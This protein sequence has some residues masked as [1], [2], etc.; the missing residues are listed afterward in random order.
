[1]KIAVLG[2]GAMGCLYG[3][4][5][6]EAGNEVCLIDVWKEHVEAINKSGLKIEGISGDRVIK[7]VKSTTT[8]E[9][10]GA[11]DLLIV[12]VKAT[13]TKEAIRGAVSLIGENTLIL[14]LQNGLGNIEKIS[15]VIGEEK[16][17]A[18]TT[19][20][21]STMLGPGH[22]RHAGTG[23]TKIGELDGSISERVQKLAKVFNDAGF[24]TQVADNVKGLIW[25]KLMANIGINA[26][27]ALTHLQ[28][29]RLLE[30]KETEE[31]LELVVKEAAEIA[32]K[33]NIKLEHDPVE[34][35][36]KVAKL[37]AA[38]RSSM[39]QDVS[40]KRMTEIAV[41]NG[42][43]VEKGEEYGVPTPVNKVLS[44]LISV[45]QRTY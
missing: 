22:I 33:E 31:L 40:R 17:I 45:I 14:T 38:N 13:L 6:A 26:L 7:C 16:I 4:T 5:L 20:H 9:D 25:D 34:T 41:I 37:T 10:F 15:E 23:D 3:G 11:A 29:G 28:N 27:T 32:K 24:P 39:L 21:G 18:G 19:A 35:A 30:Y 42:A 43:I 2:S 12:F 36:K 44:N 8:P 1:M